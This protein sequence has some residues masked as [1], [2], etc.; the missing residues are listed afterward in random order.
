MERR[1][2]TKTNETYPCVTT[3]SRLLSLLYHHHQCSN[4][5]CYYSRGLASGQLHAQLIINDRSQETTSTLTQ[6]TKNTR[7]KS[8]KDS[9]GKKA[10]FRDFDTLWPRLLAVQ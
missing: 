2:S 3:F 4:K 8:I 10:S 1:S 9:N 5:V 7:E 6:V